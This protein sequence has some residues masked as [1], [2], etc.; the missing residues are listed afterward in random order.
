MML[1][2]PRIGCGRYGANGIDS[3]ARMLIV[4]VL[5][6]A[7]AGTAC[8][9]KPLPASARNAAD[10]AIKAVTAAARTGEG[11]LDDALPLPTQQLDE[12]DRIL[13]QFSAQ[14][15]LV[16]ADAARLRRLREVQEA[17][18]EARAIQQAASDAGIALQRGALDAVDTSAERLGTTLTENFRKEL[19]A[20]TEDLAKGQ[21][22]ELLLGAAMGTSPSVDPAPELWDVAIERLASRWGRAEVSRVIAWTQWAMGVQETALEVADELEGRDTEALFQGP[23]YVRYR[24]VEAYVRYCLPVS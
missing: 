15:D 17:L 18:A 4:P 16:A 21:V 19:A 13:P 7:L 6:L 3:M 2:A 8:S 12:I 14:A 20:V 10:E 22:C 1:R 5:V 24:A 11:V 23:G 9:P